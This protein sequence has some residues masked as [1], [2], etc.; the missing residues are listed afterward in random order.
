[1]RIHSTRS[2]ALA[3]IAMATMLATA[4][5]A[6]QRSQVYAAPNAFGNWAV[7]RSQVNG[8]GTY[9]IKVEPIGKTSV[10]GEVRYFRSKDNTQVVE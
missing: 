8:P 3:V 6:G 7:V 9:T 5:L 10:V 2:V 1:M 4:A